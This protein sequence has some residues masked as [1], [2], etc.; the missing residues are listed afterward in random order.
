MFIL[1][2][3][4]VKDDIRKSMLLGGSSMREK[5]VMIY[6]SEN[7]TPCKSLLSRMEEWDISYQTKNVTHNKE[8]MVELQEKG[9][10][11]TPATFIEDQESVILGVQESKIKHALGIEM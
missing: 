7:S 6:V 4:W 11:G 1:L 8:Y 9:I 10:F 2:T 5:D 3:F